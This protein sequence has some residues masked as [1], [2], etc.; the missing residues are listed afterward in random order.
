MPGCAVLYFVKTFHMRIHVNYFPFLHPWSRDCRV[1]CIDFLQTMSNTELH[2]TR[3]IKIVV[4]GGTSRKE[5]R[6]LQLLVCWMCTADRNLPTLWEI[7]PQTTILKHRVTICC[8]IA[9]LGKPSSL[10]G[11]DQLHAPSLKNRLSKINNPHRN[12]ANIDPYI[13][14][15]PWSCCRTMIEGFLHW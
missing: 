12:L 13:I 11:G 7:P 4:C 5:G 8:G 10:P 1:K 15:A 6:F 9:I 14:L 3:C 2:K